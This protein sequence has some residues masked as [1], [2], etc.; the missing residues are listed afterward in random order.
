MPGHVFTIADAAKA[1]SVS[2]KTLNRKIKTGDLANAFKDDK[3][4]W[5]IPLEDLL[6]AGYKVNDYK[7]ESVTDTTEQVQSEP[8]ADKIK[9]LEERLRAMELRATV[10]EARLE[11]ADK[12]ILVLEAPK[13]DAAKK[14][15]FRR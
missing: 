15:W 3:G 5:K 11:Y 4:R 14:R 6:Q 1:C 9:E 7:N 2:K 8:K 13:K 12:L 10:A